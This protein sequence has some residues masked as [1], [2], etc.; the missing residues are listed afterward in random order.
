MKQSS[1]DVLLQV[2]SHAG[3]HVVSVIDG[4]DGLAQKLPDSL[5]VVLD[6]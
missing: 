6:G 4:L 3:H 1:L 5:S 2:T